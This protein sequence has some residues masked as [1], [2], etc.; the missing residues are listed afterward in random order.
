MAY[1]FDVYHDDSCVEKNLLN[2]SLFMALFPKLAAGP[3]IRFHEVAAALVERTVSRECFAAGVTRFIIGFGKKTLLANTLARGANQI[4]AIAPDHLNSGTAWLGIACYTLQIYFDFSGY[5]DMAIG[6]GQMFGFRF[7]ENFNYPYIS[8]SISE[9]WRRWH[10][11]LSS[12]FRDYLFTPLSY[13]LVTGRMREK[14]VAGNYRGNPWQTRILILLVF[15]LCGLWH[16]ANWNFIVWGLFH[17]LFLA[18]ET[19]SFGK[20]LKR[21]WR[22]LRHG[23]ALLVI[24]VGWVFF[25]VDSLAGA[26]AFLKTMFGFTRGEA[27]TPSVYFYLNNE[28]LLALVCAVAASLPIMPLVAGYARASEQACDLGESRFSANAL[29]AAKVAG[30]LLVLVLAVISLVSGTYDSFIYARF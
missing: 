8:Q 21:S 30:L 10:I 16:G 7:A 23:Y 12:W 9:F 13:L 22:P 4:M 19:F 14:I 26:T 17:G 28:L 25:R 6:L 3:I 29:A 5:T 11:S 27:L 1:L 20:L 15:S 18:A 2:F 24:M